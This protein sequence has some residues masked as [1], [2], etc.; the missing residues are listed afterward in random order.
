MITETELLTWGSR[1][2]IPGPEEKEAAFLTRVSKACL[3]A[4]EWGEAAPIT[5]SLFGFAVDWVPIHYSNKKLPFWEGAAFWIGEDPYIQMREGFKKGCY[6]GYHR[7]EVL[8][9]EAVHA[10]RLAFEEPQFEE[11]LAYRTSKKGLRK[12]IGPLFQKPWESVVFIFSLG[13]T[14][15]GNFWIPLMFLGWFG[16]RLCWT[17]WIVQRCLSKLPLFFLIYLTDQE[18]K[19][20]A[21]LSLPKIHTY[22][23]NDQTLRIRSLKLKFESHYSLS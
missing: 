16:I 11:I 2:L 14:L 1:G 6:L 8:A 9:H 10:A 4:N 23:K 7:A 19:Q 3:Y 17:Q 21:S 18:I 5:R 12:W 22:L 20:F 13:T 15:L